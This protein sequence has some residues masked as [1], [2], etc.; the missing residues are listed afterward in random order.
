MAAQ[1][2][3]SVGGMS[4]T[5]TSV[6][7]PARETGAVEGA[8]ATAE[9]QAQGSAGGTSATAAPAGE[10]AA[11]SNGIGD[12]PGQSRDEEGEEGDIV[13]TCAR[14]GKRVS[15]RW[16]VPRDIWPRARIPP[17]WS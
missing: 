5:A 16:G 14:G 8:G 4:V 17:A 15:G 13:E 11:G 10:A 9:P 2:T 12:A 7:V 6:E 3:G 1:A